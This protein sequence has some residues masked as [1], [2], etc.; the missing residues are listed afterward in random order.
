M[1][2]RIASVYL[3]AALCLARVSTS[4]GE[5]YSALRFDHVILD[6]EKEIKELYDYRDVEGGSFRPWERGLQHYFDSFRS[7]N[8]SIY[9]LH[10]ASNCQT[11]PGKYV[12]ADCGTEETIIFYDSTGSFGKRVVGKKGDILGVAYDGVRSAPGQTG[13]FGVAHTGNV[14]TALQSDGTVRLDINVEFDL[15]NLFRYP[16]RC[17]ERRVSSSCVLK[18]MKNIP[19]KG[20]IRTYS[21]DDD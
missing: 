12:A 9:V 4:A 21:G 6:H 1:S 15:F 18:S 13:C 14:L 8:G 17:A 2:L 20:S 11:A 16:E 5:E 3:A 10:R 7:G 19:V